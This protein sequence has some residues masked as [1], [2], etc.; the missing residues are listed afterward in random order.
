M[1]NDIA[2]GKVYPSPEVVDIPIAESKRDHLVQ[3]HPDLFS[4]SVLTRAQAR[5]QTQDVD[6]SD[7]VFASALS[8]DS[9]PPAGETESGTAN[10]GK[11]GGGA[12]PVADHVLPLTREALISSQSGDPSL[13]KCFAAVEVVSKRTERQSFSVDNG[14]LMR[15]WMSPL[16]KTDSVG[17]GEPVCQVVVPVAYRR[18]VLE[19][20]HEHPWAGHLGVTKTYDRILK[21][22][23][24]PGMKTEVVRFCKTCST[25]QVVGKPNQVVPPA[26]LTPIPAVGRLCWPIDED[27]VW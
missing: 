4:V 26:P 20:A 17:R 18:H 5:K 23:F 8:E 12:G 15:R 10:L 9:F 6:L 7:S 19:V 22:F 11:Y 24:W 16:G 13:R 21:H 27:K 25:C 2:G 3:C 1:G 14:V